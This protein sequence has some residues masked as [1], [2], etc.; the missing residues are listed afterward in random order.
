MRNLGG[1]SHSLFTHSAF[2]NIEPVQ[3]VFQGM[4]YVYFTMVATTFND[5]S[6]IAT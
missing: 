2:C 3:G 5:S 4:D 6:Q 1:F